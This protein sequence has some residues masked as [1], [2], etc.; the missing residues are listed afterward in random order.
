MR[1]FV[2]IETKGMCGNLKRLFLLV[3]S[4]DHMIQMYVLMHPFS[5]SFFCTKAELQSV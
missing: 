5:L 4:K 3:W 1:R 2:Q